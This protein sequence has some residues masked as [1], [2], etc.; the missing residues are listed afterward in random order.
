GV[1]VTMWPLCSIERCEE[2]DSWLVD[3]FLLR[4]TTL[5]SLVL[6]EDEEE[7]D[8]CDLTRGSS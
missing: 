2:N 7:E 6:P 4:R 3:F 5:L 1:D 8:L